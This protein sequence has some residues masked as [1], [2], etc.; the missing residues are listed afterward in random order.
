MPSPNSE[1]GSSILAKLQDQGCPHM[2]FYIFF[3]HVISKVI[4]TSPNFTLL[5]FF[6]S[7]SSVSLSAFV[8]S[9]VLSYIL[10]SAP[11]VPPVLLLGV[12]HQFVCHFCLPA[13]WAVE[14]LAVLVKFNHTISEA[15]VQGAR[16]SVHKFKTSHVRWSQCTPWVLSLLYHMG[17]IFSHGI[18]KHPCAHAHTLPWSLAL[19][20][21]Y[22]LYHV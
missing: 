3:P 19:F 5:H 12:C 18:K 13:K 8:H 1:V 22:H 7:L 15:W 16:A 10:T 11:T 6:L 14:C 20:K 21:R 2:F 9:S 17:N 4:K